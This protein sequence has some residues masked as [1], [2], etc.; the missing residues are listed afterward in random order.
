M[1]LYKFILSN[2]SI[3]IS[4]IT[5]LQENTDTIYHKSIFVKALLDWQWNSQAHPQLHTTIKT[6]PDVWLLLKN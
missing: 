4:Y 5:I 2:D 1:Y 6:I 3:T